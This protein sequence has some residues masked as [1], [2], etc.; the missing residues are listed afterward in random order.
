LPDDFLKRWI[1]I[2]NEKPITEDVIEEEYPIFARNLRWS[3]IVNKIS[4]DNDI[5]GEFEE[6]KEYSKE[7]LRQQ[8]KQYAPAGGGFSDEDLDNL[9]NNML[10]K[11]DHVKK[12]YDAVME[13]KLFNVIKQQITVEEEEVSFEDFFKS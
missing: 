2:S 4:K 6:I 12:S 9:N 5:K 1:K 10:S 11:E 8:L 7:A 3:L 13:Q